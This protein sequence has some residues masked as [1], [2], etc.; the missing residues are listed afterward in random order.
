MYRFC[1]KTDRNIPTII[2][3]YFIAFFIILL[4]FPMVLWGKVEIYE[5]FPNTIDDTNLE[6]IELRNTGCSDI[7]ISGYIL[8]DMSTK[9]Y[10]FPT[11]S[12]ISPKNTIRID[13]SNSKIILNNV[14]EILYL[15]QP[16]GTIEDQLS[17]ATSTK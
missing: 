10:I 16:D 5:I 3:C 9:Q 13:R 7:D 15:K 17:Y 12:I 8:E 6:Y 1:I 4:F 11:S 2:R 14:D